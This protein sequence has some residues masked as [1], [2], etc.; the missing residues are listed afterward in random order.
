MRGFCYCPTATAHAVGFAPS[1]GPRRP[2]HVSDRRSRAIFAVGAERQRLRSHAGEF[3]QSSGGGYEL[4]DRRDATI[5]AKAANRPG[6]VV[7]IHRI[8]CQCRNE[9]RKCRKQD[10]VVKR[11]LAH[12]KT[13]MLTFTRH[14]IISSLRVYFS[15]DAFPVGV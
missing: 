15:L 13:P 6:T 9:N 1:L 4:I 7:E 12:S 14:A 5:R 3:N 2:T 10:S 8:C 11:F